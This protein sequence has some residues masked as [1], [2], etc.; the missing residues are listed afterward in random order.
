MDLVAVAAGAG[1]LLLML[2]MHDG[3][4]CG[5]RAHGAA[6][7]DSHDDLHTTKQ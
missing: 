7:T 4:H 5:Q 2:V 3:C 6:H 1:V